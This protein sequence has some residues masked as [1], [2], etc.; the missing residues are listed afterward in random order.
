MVRVLVNKVSL[1]SEVL[2]NNV[3]KR[4]NSVKMLIHV[5]A[6]KLALNLVTLFVFNSVKVMSMSLVISV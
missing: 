2:V 1:E 3:D 6:V 5:R 4:V